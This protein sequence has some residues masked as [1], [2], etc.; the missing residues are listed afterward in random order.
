MR[1][2]PPPQ[3]FILL[4][5]LLLQASQAFAQT[6][7]LTGVV[8]DSAN[9]PL[10][11]ATVSVKGSKASTTTAADGSFTLTV[12]S[13][14]ITL[15]VSYVGFNPVSVPVSPEQTEVSVTMQSGSNTISD[16]VVTAL[17][18]KKDERKLGY[19]VSTVSG[20]QLTKARETNVALSLG[21]Q[22]AGLKVTGTSGGPGGTARILLRGMPSMNSG[23]S[24]L[25]VINGVPMDNSNRGSS[26]EWGGADAGD[27]IGNINPDDIETMTVL[28]EQAA[29]A[30]YGARASNGVILI[31]TKSG[32]KGSP[33][34]EYNLNY[35][36]DKPVDFSDYQTEYGQGQ[37][38]E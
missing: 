36:A 38:G 5:L 4:F 22:V 11:A 34:I 17:G 33:N 23:G 31:T 2:Y 18:I 7:P 10:V 32:V 16:V 1:K 29:S 3:L 8:R 19:S 14:N 13:G 15:E 28:K 21:G 24:P 35:V 20:S 27:G 9:Q 37:N 26:G 12:P 30:L 6:R 25:F